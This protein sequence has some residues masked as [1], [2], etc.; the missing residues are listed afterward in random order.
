[1]SF[2]DS[3]QYMEMLKVERDREIRSRQLERIA[4]MAA[5]CCDAARSGILRIFGLRRRKATSS[6]TVAC[7]CR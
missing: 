4:S 1:M 5:R 6:Q 3:R 2:Y 7:G